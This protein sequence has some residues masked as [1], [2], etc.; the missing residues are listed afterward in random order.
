MIVY[1]LTLRTRSPL[2]L[3]SR[4][5][6][7]GGATRSRDY[8][9]GSVL[10]GALAGAL[11]RAGH[12]SDSAWFQTLFSQELVRYGCL[13]PT[14]EEAVTATWPLPPTAWSCKIQS[15]FLPQQG[16]LPS[17]EDA[18]GVLDTLVSQLAHTWLKHERCQHDG[19]GS[20]REPLG[21]YYAQREDGSYLQ[22]THSRRLITRTAISGRWGSARHGS[23]HTVEAI[24][25]GQAFVGFVHVADSAAQDARRAL[26]QVRDTG[27]LRLGLGLSRG[28]GQVDISSIDEEEGHLGLAQPLSERWRVPDLSQHISGLSAERFAFSITLYSD[29]ILL[30]DF[31]RYQVALNE[32]AWRRILRYAGQ[33]PAGLA[34]WPQSIRYHWGA[35]AAHPVYN[36]RFAP[37]WGKRSSEEL[38][39][40]RG[41]VFVCTALRQEEAA[42]LALL[43]RLEATG[44]G[45]RRAEGFG[46]IVVGHPW[47]REEVLR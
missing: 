36:W 30:D 13:Y 27:A 16:T 6:A 10:R 37:G 14:E 39:V 12:S 29:A 2:V 8:I 7:Q 22:P 41:S 4:Q 34:N 28:L 21:G 31:G 24:E 44:I 47:H 40:T 46:Q 33:P 9:P 43:E 15:G 17:P 35:T 25:D 18:H 38:A 5:A 32:E 26:Q 20:L 45:R 42:V 1:R 11:L 3:A 23:L 19:C